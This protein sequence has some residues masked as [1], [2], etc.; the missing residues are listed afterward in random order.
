MEEGERKY[1]L[2]NVKKLLKRFSKSVQREWGVARRGDFFLLLQ[3]IIRGE[4]G[5]GEGYFGQQT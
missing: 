4:G 5:W 1:I 3:E 2:S